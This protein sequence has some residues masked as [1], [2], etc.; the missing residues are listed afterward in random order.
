[1]PTVHVRAPRPCNTS[2][3][4]RWHAAGDVVEMS[5]EE[6]AQLLEIPDA[7]FTLADPP[8]AEQ[9]EEPPPPASKGSGEVL[10]QAPAPAPAVPA[11]APRRPRKPRTARVTE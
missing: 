1:M 5:P 9:L 7:G 2:L 6:A 4:Y 8:P 11:P 10:E 3:G